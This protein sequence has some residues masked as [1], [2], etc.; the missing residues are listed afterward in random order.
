MEKCFKITDKIFKVLGGF[1]LVQRKHKQF[2]AFSLA[3]RGAKK[4]LTKRNA[5]TSVSLGATSAEGSAFRNRKPF[6]KG[7]T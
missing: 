4:K 7:L 2:A 5:E 6:K 1:L 3:E